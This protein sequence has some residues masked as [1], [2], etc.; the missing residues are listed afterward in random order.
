MSTPVPP[1]VVLVVEDEQLLRE[2]VEPGSVEAGLVGKHAPLCSP[3]K[4]L[5][6]PAVP[7]RGFSFAARSTGYFTTQFACRFGNVPAVTQGGA[8]HDHPQNNQS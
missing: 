8:T 1:L 6:S 4:S 2:M 7:R 3:A 5:Q